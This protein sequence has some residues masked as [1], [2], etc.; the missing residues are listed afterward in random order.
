MKRLHLMSI[1]VGLVLAGCGGDSPEKQLASAKDYLQ[2]KDTKAAVIQ[3]KNVLQQQP[4]SGEARFLLGSTLLKQGDVAGAEVELRKALA[5]Q[6]AKDEVVP[7]LAR[8]MLMLGQAKKVVDEFS[9]TQL[10]TPAARAN[11]QTSLAAAYATLGQGSASQAALDAALAA[12]KNYVP[13]Q[14]LDARRK[15][16]ARDF[17]GSLA[18]V[19]AVIQAD[20]SNSAAW[21][22]KGDVL[23]YG[24]GDADAA[25]E[26]FRKAVAVEPGSLLARYALA[27][28]LMRKGALDEA[29]QQVEQMKQLAPKHPS[30]QFME[31][32]LALQKK[33]FKTARELSLQLVQ[34]APKDPRV[35]QL[36]GAA[37]LGGGSA[38]QAEIYLS[39]ALQAAPQMVMAK[40]LLISSYLRTGQPAKA[41]ATLN[42]LDEK[43]DFDAGMY[44]L[45]GE[46]YLHNGDAQRAEQAFAQSL[47]LDPSDARKRT[48]L[49]VTHLASGRVEAS[50]DELQDIAAADTGVTADMALISA[51]LRRQEFAKALAAVDGLE[52]KQP[53]KPLAANLRGRIQM[54]QKDTAGARK[55]FERALAIEPG[56]FPAIA[57]LATL[58]MADKR[59]EDAKKRFEAALAKDPKSVQALVALAQLAASDPA[60]RSEALGWLQ[61]AVDAAPLNP[62]PRLLLIDAYAR[63]GDQKQ[64]LTTAQSAVSAIPDNTDLLI[65][66]GRMQQVSGDVNQAINTYGK[67]VAA[68][69]LSPVPLVRLAEAQTAAKDHK[70]AAQSL[71]R[72]LEIKPDFLDAQRG[73]IMIS[74]NDKNYK[75]ALSVARQ[76]EQQRPKEALGP[77][78]EGDIE[79]AR[80]GWTAAIDAYKR[81]LQIAPVTAVAI[82]VHSTLLAGGSAKEAEQFSQSWLAKQPK[83]V[84]FLAYLGEAAIAGGDFALAQKRLKAV[85]Q[86][87]PD[88]AVTLNNLAW[89][90]LQLKQTDDALRAAER[91]NTLVPD[92]PAFMDT[93]S[94]VLAVK[95]EH[96]RAIELQTKVVALQ[97]ENHGF[98][99]NLARIYVAAG[100]K[101]K[102]RTELEALVK[103]GE[104]YPAQREVSAMLNAL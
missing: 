47:K 7:D 25:L 18:A 44:A 20:A 52:K 64:A 50:L 81:A 1:A 87:Q 65:A 70:A 34:L 11:L 97:P 42:S 41:L 17:E 93:L 32:T 71:R 59:P 91:A 36:A 60:T 76:V 54:L 99:M 56:F 101:A 21:V 2:K 83:D 73:L 35:L 53:D 40:R 68:Q 16:A 74:V 46:V 28:Q 58:D 63:L 22:L 66:L 94:A 85:L 29:G 62:T 102:A 15:A 39:R 48:A 80:K 27:A 82:K 10:S 33:D 31:A 26:A 95:G 23:Q 19:E 55:S 100:D 13:A 104:K 84:A 51:H 86:L 45:A 37:E 49:A 75:E 98:R 88:H 5:A 103:L 78:M 79:S 12:D 67:A 9:G 14:L 8:A 61:K 3:I 89:V 77:L 72:A 4:E 38:A 92:Q 30:T 24:K 96:A 69:P 90:D 43:R 57:S 6:Y